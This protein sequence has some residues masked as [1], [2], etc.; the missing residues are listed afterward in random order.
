MFPLTLDLLP[1]QTVAW[2]FLEDSMTTEVGYGGAAG[3]GK[4]YLGCYLAFYLAKEFPGSRG[5]IGRKE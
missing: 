4:S 2:D 5:G 3:G 1:K